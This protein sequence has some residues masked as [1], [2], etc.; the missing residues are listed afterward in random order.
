MSHH[1]RSSQLGRALLA[2]AIAGLMIGQAPA[3]AAEQ[4]LLDQIR[5]QMPLTSTVP[6]NA[7]LNPYAVFVAPVSAGKV[8]AGDVLVTNFN[9]VSNLQGTGGTIIAYTPETRTTRVLISLP[10]T[11]PQC[12][13]G[14]GLTA[15]LVMLKSGWIIVGSTASTDGTTRTKGDGCLLV[16]SPEGQLAHVWSGVNINGPWSNIAISDQGATATLFVTMVGFDM[17]GPEIRDPQTGFSVTHKAARVLRLKLSIAPGQAPVIVD[18]TVVADGFSARADRD[19]F[20]IAPTGLALGADGT[21]YVADALDNRITAIPDALTRKESGGTG[22]EVTRDG[23]L[24]RPLVMASTPA[25]HLLVTN[26]K[27]GQVIEIDPVAGR[28]LFAR[29]INTN[30][31]QSPPGNGNL[32]GLAV[33]TDGKGFYYVQDDVNNLMEAAP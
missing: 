2:T 14:I 29:W 17:K 24:R 30:P 4:G 7:D 6:A 19:V 11:L 32:F 5:R 10:Q 16:I 1:P 26:A 28:Q 21:L 31:V 25:G 12:P 33:R 15:A 18:E 8:Q 9:N 23:L 22:R 20:M 27:N 3:L 13:G